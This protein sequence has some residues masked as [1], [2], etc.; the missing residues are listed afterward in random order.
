MRM[1]KI[2]KRATIVIGVVFAAV[3][4]VVLGIQLYLN[5]EQAKQN[6]QARVNQ[7]IPGTL[8]WKSNRF[9]IL[10][11]Q[12]QL[13]QV[14]LTGPD[15]KKVMALDRLLIHISWTGLLKGELNIHD[16]LLE[17]PHLY[18]VR[19]HS[20]NFNVIQAFYTTGHKPTESGNNGG[21]PFNILL[22]RLNVTNGSIDYN[23][24]EKTAGNRI[25]RLELRNMDLTVTDGN[26]LT[27]SGRILCRIGEGH[28]Q[29]KGARTDIDHLSFDA[30]VRNDSVSGLLFDMTTDGLDARITGTV[31]NL[32]TNKPILDLRLNS[33]A[34]LSKLRHFMGLGPDFS[35]DIQADSNLKGTIENPD[36]SLQLG[37]KGGKLSGRQIQRIHLKCRLKNKLLNIIDANADTPWGGFHIKGDVDFTKALPD[38]VLTSSFIADAVSYK[39]FIQQK[40]AQLKNL[41]PSIRGLKGAVHADMK[42]EGKGIEPKSLRAE[43]TLEIYAEKLAAAKMPSTVDVHV[44][45]L[46]D[47]A[48]GRITV[49]NLAA[50][51]HGVRLEMVGSY[52][53]F[54]H[55]T[56][57]RFGLNA[58]D[59]SDM[60]LNP[61]VKGVHGRVNITGKISGTLREP[62]MDARLTGERLRFEK[63]RFD[64]ADASFR[65]SKG[66]LSMNRGEIASGDSRVALSGDIQILDPNNL[67]FLRHPVFTAALA[68]SGLSLKDFIQGMRGTFDLNGRIEGDIS[69][70]RGK[71]EVYGKNV[72][73]GIQKIHSVRL[74]SRIDGRRFEIDP[75]M[76]AIVPGEQILLN[77]W[78]SL[79]KHYELRMASTDISIKNIQKLRF[80]K[81]NGGKISF[82]LEG[83]GEFANPQ[84]KGKAIV[85]GLTINDKKIGKIPFNIGVENRT[86]Y[87]DGGLNF[88]LKATYGL[89]TRFFSTSLRFDHTVL[90]PYLQLFGKQDLSGNITGN[91]DVRGKF[92]EPIQ[93]DGGITI[94]QLALFWKKKAVVT[95][96]DLR[97]VVNKNEISVPNMR[98]S[99]LEQGYFTISGSGKLWQNIRLKAEGVIP[100]SVLPVFTDSIADAGGK[101]RIS[102]RVSENGLQPTFE[103]E[104]ALENGSI[105]V[106]GLFQ[107]FHDINGHI[108]ATPKAVALDNIQGMLGDGRFGLSG[109][110]DLD[111]YRWSNIGLKLKADNLPITI[112]DLLDVRLSSELDVRGS[113]KRSL[114]KG[115][116]TILEGRYT[117]DVRLNPIQGIARESQA[118]PPST[119]T[120][121]W[122]FFD[123]MGLDC[124]IRNTEAFVVDNN[125]ALLT[126]KPDLHVQG[127]VN[128][129]LITGRAEVESGTVYFQNNEFNVKKGVLD[130]INP[131]KIEP[132]VDIQADVKIRTWSVTLNVSGTLD[133]LKFNLSSNPSESEQDILSLMIAGKTTQELIAGQGGSLLSPKQMLAG[134]LAEN[135]QKE[136]KNATGLDIVTL[137]YNGTGN[138]GTPGGVNVT[139]GKE[140]SKRVTV[141]YGAQTTN[142]KVIQSV[143]AE[144]K[145]LETLLMNTFEDNEGNYGAGIQF[146][147]E[148]R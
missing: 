21:L 122:P 105:E 75:L 51:A 132:T 118:G 113:P 55:R 70:P 77:G 124:R 130:F 25:D 43:T 89:Q 41:A 128:H 30:N 141:K 17:N 34:S 137:G 86:A 12:V 4:L 88:D 98:L 85:E 131:Y 126:I 102:L 106:P 18:L 144:Y 42:L 139:L 27:H 1:M 54:S 62:F 90:T 7:V 107:R 50:D 56:L 140:L 45:A 3:F 142:G 115:D 53:I 60:L 66:Q 129:P 73:F 96:R 97:A 82:D 39:L 87:I 117:K 35:G 57:A 72:D 135:A 63:V 59:L 48:N 127:T 110:V 36:I 92:Q 61:G 19:D 64:S 69:R 22:R 136:I 52:D 10:C 80:L 93:I 29:I 44:K 119:S 20:G 49:R 104:A 83:K 112:P 125:I 81:A 121:P 24:S 91:I 47:M 74:T 5:T 26:L 111:R 13:K 148:F 28:I 95:G 145:F 134:V 11:G 9:S 101:A 16:L 32:F 6:I 94:D 14:R 99:L 67:R 8:T 103:F 146:R 37:Y 38:D 68:G 15:N 79:N 100:F 65:F 116:I 46:A 2:F 147:L 76:L 71:F 114:I 33:R 108:R 78:I 23:T 40:A 133:N 138:G 84:L 143:I 123:N 120:T 31:E 109:A 58:P